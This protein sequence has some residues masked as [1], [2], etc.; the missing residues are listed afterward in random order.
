MGS[1]LSP[2]EVAR[3]YG[4]EAERYKDEQPPHT[5]EITKPFYLQTTEVSRA[6]WKRVIGDNPSKIK[7]CG[8]DCPV[9]NVSWDDTQKFIESLN[10]MEGINKYRLPTESEWEYACRAGTK[11]PFFTGDC[12]STD[13]ANYNGNNP[14]K[15]CP[16]GAYREK[17]VKVGSFQPNGWGLY[18]MHGNVF[19]WVQ[20]WHDDDY[21]RSSSDDNPKG[22]DKGL[23]RVQRGGS[24]D[25]DARSIRSA[26]R[27]SYLP[28]YSRHNIGFRVARDF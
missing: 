17:T 23:F 27:R 5:V 28:F 22:P 6:Q 19:E 26:S 2:E 18:N 14:G 3:K 8:D 21:Y 1:Q 13:Q 10:R 12:I 24:W 7:N 11:T 20:D 15:N 25:N 4:G 16:K 9:E